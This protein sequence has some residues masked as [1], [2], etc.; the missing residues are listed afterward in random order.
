MSVATRPS[1]I[2]KLIG[3]I[4]A[5]LSRSSSGLPS[6]NTA[7]CGAVNGVRSLRASV[8]L[9]LDRQYQEHLLLVAMSKYLE[10]TKAMLRSQYSL[11]R[12]LEDQLDDKAGNEDN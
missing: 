6:S 3:F 2:S 1:L 12:R 5:Y 10:T 11:V 4:S 8:R 9:L 7:G